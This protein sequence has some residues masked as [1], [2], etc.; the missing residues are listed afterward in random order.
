MARTALGLAA[1][2][3]LTL[4][5]AATSPASAQQPIKL[6]DINSY[7]RFATFAVPYRNAMLL[8]I[9]EINGKGGIIGRKFELVWRDDNVNTGD[10]T[11]MA[12]ELVSREKIDI[13]TG[14]LFS[15]IGVAIADF[16][17]QK[18][19]L[20]MAAMPLTDVITM[21]SGNR[22][23]FRL[24]ANTFMQVSILVDAVKQSGHKKWAIVAPNYEYGQS[25]AE[26]FKRVVKA[27]I[28]GSEIVAEHYPALGK[29]DA[30]ATVTAIA[31][32]KPDA[33]FSA[34]FASDVVQFYREGSTRGLFENRPVISPILGEPE[35]LLPMKDEFPEGWVVTGYPWDQL[36]EPAHKAFVEAYQKRFNETPRF[37][38]LIGYTE[39]YML[40]DA[41]A[42]A[43]SA[44]TEALI[45]V[46]PGMSFDTPIGKISIRAIDH[47]ATFGTWVGKLA[48]KGAGG[49]LVDFKYADGAN[50]LYPEAEVRAVRKD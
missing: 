9:D 30:G 2:G 45:K 14:T 11:R 18:K 20:F 38:S 17:N 4:A 24:K 33:I 16:A 41:I 19:T 12:D 25:A 27:K 35:W 47:Q 42:K 40:R 31:Q 3:F 49:A 43:G 48:R 23:T 46:L 37:S 7:S 32:A 10:A 8:A 21:A 6:G 26:A 29:I 50:F 13:L 22:Y 34:L 36:T 39:V 44:D 15:N 5:M 1:C 28:P